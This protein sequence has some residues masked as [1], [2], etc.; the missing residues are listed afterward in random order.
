M[1]DLLSYYKE[2]RHHVSSTSAKYITNYTMKTYICPKCKERSGLEILYGYP[3]VG[4]ADAYARGEIALGGCCIDRDS[5]DRRCM[6]CGHEWKIVR[7]S[8]INYDAHIGGYWD[9]ED[10]SN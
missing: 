7:R 3:H 10:F 5:P 1:S 8:K 2:K 6:S 9:D 4:L